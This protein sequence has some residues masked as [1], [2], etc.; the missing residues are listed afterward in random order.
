VAVEDDDL[1]DLVLEAVHP[2]PVPARR[3]LGLVAVEGQV[4]DAEPVDPAVRAAAGELGEPVGLEDGR[5]RPGIELQDGRV[6]AG[7]PQVDPRVEGLPRGQVRPRRQ[8]DDAAAGTG[9]LDRRLDRRGVVRGAV[10]G[11]AVVT[12][13]ERGLRAGRGRQRVRGARGGQRGDRTGTGAGGHRTEPGER[14]AA[15]QR[16]LVCVHVGNPPSSRP[17]SVADHPR[18]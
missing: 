5:V 16:V 12:H 13:V 14:G 1:G 2:Y 9:G 11:G 18:P 8:E 10:A 6:A 17:P 4:A 15:A 3:V 7:A